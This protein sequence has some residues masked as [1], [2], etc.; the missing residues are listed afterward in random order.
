M[1]LHDFFKKIGYD[2]FENYIPHRVLE[3]FGLNDEAI[4]EFAKAANNL[5][6]GLYEANKATYK[7]LR[8]GVPVRDELGKPK[9]TVWLI[10]WN[11]PKSNHFAIAEEVTVH[12]PPIDKPFLL[13]NPRVRLH[14]RHQLLVGHGQDCCQK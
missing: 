6:N 13:A 12:R 5:S 8:Y 11:E 9:E 1:I 10:D 3:G 14:S 7:M 2:N 4:D